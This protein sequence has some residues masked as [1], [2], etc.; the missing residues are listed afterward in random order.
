MKTHLIDI[1][2]LLAFFRISLRVIDVYKVDANRRTKTKTK[3]RLWF[4]FVILVILVPN[5]NGNPDGKIIK[6]K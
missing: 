4:G 3:L 6:I 1:N 5:K 2:I